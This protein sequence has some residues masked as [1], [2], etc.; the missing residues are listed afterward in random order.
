MDGRVKYWKVDRYKWLEENPY[1]GPYESFS[2]A[3]DWQ[4]RISKVHA[5]SFGVIKTLKGFE[6]E[7]DAYG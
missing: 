5:D 6:V 4:E 3:K 7:Q 2:E 1:R